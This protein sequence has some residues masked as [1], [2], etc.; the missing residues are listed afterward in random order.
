MAKKQEILVVV[1]KVKDYIKSKKMMTS[2]DLAPALSAE[3][4]ALL[5]KAIKRC[6]ANKRSTVR[7]D[8]L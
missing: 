4:Q 7:A 3:V 5:D 6:K 1:S 2:S 8:D